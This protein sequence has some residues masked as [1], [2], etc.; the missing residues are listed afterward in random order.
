MRRLIEMRFA[1]PCS[2]VLVTLAAA[3][4]QGNPGPPVVEATYEGGSITPP[5]CSHT[6]TTRFGAEAPEL[7]TTEVGADPTIKHVHLGLAADP[8]TT[9]AV[10]WRTVDDTTKA[11]KIMFGTGGTFDRGVEGL[12][13]AYREG[14]NNVGH[15]VRIHEAHLCGLTADTEY[16][17]QVVSDDRHVSPTYT[18]RTAPDI[19]ATPDA[20]VVIAT[21]GDSRGGYEVW[22]QLVAELIERTPDLIVF[23]GDAVTVGQAQV[24]WEEFFAAAEPLFSKVPVVSAHGN[25]ELNSI[26]FYSQFAMPGDE[27]NFSF[28]Y[29]HAHLTVLND[30]PAQVGDVTG[31]IKDFLRRDLVSATTPWKIVNHHRPMYSASTRHGSNLML[32][33][34]WA[35]IIDQHKADLVLSGHDHDYER[36]KPM[37]N[38][39]AQASAADGTIYVVSGGAGA[40]LYG[41]G[42]DPIHTE[43]SASIHSAAVLRVR[44]TMLQFDAFDEH[45]AAVDT[46]TIAK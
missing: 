41:N 18:F 2:S 16:S 39:Q 45:G 20:E 31:K 23:S 15:V 25:H 34:E 24:E 14:V 28:D 26:N 46:F 13:W 44:A 6:V 1:T 33:S 8:R 27:E 22:A 43:R 17:Y 11:G 21:V 10:T 12:T 40:E 32:R 29:G 35:P 5:G 19:A 3:C 30:S 4:V 36:S 42:M 9:I 38:G 7:A 37:R